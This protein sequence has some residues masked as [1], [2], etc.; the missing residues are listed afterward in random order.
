MSKKIQLIRIM[1]DDKKKTKDI[2]EAK[3]V[4]VNMMISFKLC[5]V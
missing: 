3:L 4:F 1:T 2:L 5:A